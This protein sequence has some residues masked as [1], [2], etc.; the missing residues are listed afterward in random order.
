MIPYS[1]YEDCFYEDWALVGVYCLC[2]CLS[3][4]AVFRSFSATESDTTLCFFVTSTA[5]LTDFQIKTYTPALTVALISRWPQAAEKDADA[6]PNGTV[7]LARRSM[8]L[9]VISAHRAETGTL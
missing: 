8:A 4:R 7:V 5:E 2:R 6:T 1:R 9:Q 3:G